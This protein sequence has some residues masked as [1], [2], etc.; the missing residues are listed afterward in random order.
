MKFQKIFA[1]VTLI[2][3]ALTFV[4]GL[5]FCSGVLNAVRQ[6]SDEME[7]YDI[8]AND[9]YEYSQ[10]INGAIVIMAIVLIVGAVLLYV[11]GCNKMRNYYATNY[12]ATGIFVAIAVAYAIFMLV[13][14]ATCISYAGRIDY[15]AWREYESMTNTAGTLIHPQYYN[16]SLATPVLGILFSLAVLA[17]AAGWV[18]N[19]I[20]KIK[21]MKGE[22]VLLEKNVIGDAGQM[23]VA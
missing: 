16:D 15:E 5:V 11:F 12:I 14:C 20:W 22:K 10:G 18:L 6:Y 9:L 2:T 4:L 17:E 3:A 19:L 13:V 7:R 1:L 23:E 21:L 8:G